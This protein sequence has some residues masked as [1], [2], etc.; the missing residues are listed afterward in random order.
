MDSLI[1][2]ICLKL[3]FFYIL[4]Q[5]YLNARYNIDPHRELLFIC[6]QSLV[7]LIGVNIVVLALK[8]I[9]AV[10]RLIAIKRIQ[11]N[12]LCLH[13][14]VCA[15]YNYF[16]YI[17]TYACMYIFKNYLHA[18]TIYIKLGLCKN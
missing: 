8:N 9:R 16:V 6:L 11:N 5:A 1:C 7:Y 12:S 13:N 17:N 3:F 18:N 10:Q 15:V 4:R 14:Y 2:L